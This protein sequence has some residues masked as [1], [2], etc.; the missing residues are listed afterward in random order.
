[1]RALTPTT[2]FVLTRASLMDL[3]RVDH[4]VYTRIMEHLLVSVADRLR[5]ASREAASLRD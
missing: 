3:R 5:Q 2:C 4:L 1:M